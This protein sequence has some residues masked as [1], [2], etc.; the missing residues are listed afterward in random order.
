MQRLE[1]QL[2]KFRMLCERVGEEVRQ[3]CHRT[4]QW[5]L[6]QD[7]LHT[8]MCSPLLLPES[9]SEAWVDEI[10]LRREHSPETSFRP[11]EFQ[12]QL[13]WKMHITPHWRLKA[14]K[15]ASTCLIA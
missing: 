8:R 1:V 14:M 9:A 11:Q 7:M 6:L 10:V 3:T 5:L 12:C 4:N 13:M 2:E 15:S